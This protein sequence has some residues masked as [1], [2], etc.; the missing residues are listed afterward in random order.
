MAAPSRW[1]PPDPVTPSAADS[2][3]RVCMVHCSDYRVDSRIQRQA[4][5]LA[6]RGDRVDLVCLTPEGRQSVGRGTIHTHEVAV[7]KPRGGA[8]AYLAGY[9]RFF[10]GALRLVSALDRERA[11]DVV[12]IHNMPDFLTFTGLRPKL[13]GASV[14]LNL[15]DTFPELFATMFGLPPGHPLVRMIRVEERVSAAAADALIFVTDEARDLVLARGVR[16]K[17]TEV[18]M[19]TPDERLFGERREPV[20]LPARGPVRAI[21]HGGLAPRFG[22]ESLVDAFGLLADREPELSLDVYGPNPQAAREIAARA[23]RVAPHSVR[24][25][26]EPT[27]VEQIPSRLARA[28]IGVVPTLRDHF[29]ELLL[30][31][32]L[33][34][35]V[36]MGLPVVASRLPVIER[37]FTDDQVLFFQPGSVPALCDALLETRRD[38]EA[39]RRRAHRA[40]ARLA[41]IEWPR[42]RAAYLELMDQLAGGASGRRRPVRTSA[43]R[44]AATSRAGA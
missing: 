10:A 5:A 14:A 34:E 17:R 29:T 41:E 35:C 27:P 15:H 13:R 36:H 1:R 37:Y 6:A 2:G 23:A 24:V 8:R 28:Q 33:L 3:L 12:E 11:F 21:Y 26:P 43:W 39:A 4:R 18:V 31:V 40:S 44:G 9:T 22:V 16:A 20:A 7:G 42:Q 32:K 30:P 19:N 25:A 38:P